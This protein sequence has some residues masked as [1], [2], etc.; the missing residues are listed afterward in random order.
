MPG[1]VVLGTREGVVF[2]RPA[3][4]QWS[5]TSEK[6]RIQ[7]VS[8][9]QDKEADLQLSRLMWFSPEMNQNLLML[10]DTADTMGKYFEDLKQLRHL[11]LLRDMLKTPG[12]WTAQRYLLIQLRIKNI[13]QWKIQLKRQAN[14]YGRRKP[15]K[16][17]ARFCSIYH[18]V[19][20]ILWLS[21][22]VIWAKPK[23]S[24]RWPE[25]CGFYTG[26]DRPDVIRSDQPFDSESG[27]VWKEAT[28]NQAE[29]GFTNTPLCATHKDA[30]R[31][32]LNIWPIYKGQIILRINFQRKFLGRLKL[33]YTDL[34]KTSI[35]IYD[36]NSINGND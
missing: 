21:S 31:A 2:I 5:E 12:Q 36:L 10:L 23:L 24:S 7:D 14:Y 16:C 26:T 9:M 8:H 35:K 17:R 32:L 6:T 22:Q 18:L 25:S 28:G 3:C 20:A 11:N 34:K 4:Q 13:R 29:Y 30:L 33:G 27:P 15:S 1:D 19:S